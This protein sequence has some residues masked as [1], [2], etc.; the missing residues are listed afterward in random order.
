MD[1]QPSLETAAEPAAKDIA[2]NSRGRVIV[3]IAVATLVLAGLVYLVSYWVS[4]TLSNMNIGIAT[5]HV[6]KRLSW[7]KLAGEVGP[8]NNPTTFAEIVC[9]D[10]D[11]DGADEILFSTYKHGTWLY[12]L[13]GEKRELT[14]P[15]QL[16][17]LG[18]RG[19]DYDGNGCDDLITA[20]GS[21]ASVAICDFT[22]NR[23]GEFDLKFYLDK[24]VIADAD[25][26]GTKELLGHLGA[27]YK[28]TAIGQAGEVIPLAE[29]PCGCYNPT[30]GDIDGDGLTELLAIDL[31]SRSL[32]ACGLGQ[33]PTSY[34]GFP[35]GRDPLLWPVGSADLDGDGADEVFASD[36]GYL[37]PATGLYTKLAY[38]RSS[39][40]Q[41][42]I[43]DA[44]SWVADLDGD[45]Q[46]EIIT[47][48]IPEPYMGLN[49]SGFYIFNPD[50]SCRHYA[51]LG[52][53]IKTCAIVHDAEST[54]HVVVLTEAKLSIYP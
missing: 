7:R 6:G 8:A 34:P 52:S 31:S 23:L 24:P 12:E 46:P 18:S 49:T 4:A 27:D 21:T 11:G 20:G 35:V 16:T 19:W 14:W 32:M 37:N 25:G 26:N 45:G 17:H 33:E 38:P 9:G 22:G 40:R 10:F 28:T 41:R 50:G 39:Q 13:D 54:A 29:M 51:E 1:S 3:L 2:H 43:S 47:C 48:D 36:Q 30:F 42:E 44:G 53:P 5:V 15:S